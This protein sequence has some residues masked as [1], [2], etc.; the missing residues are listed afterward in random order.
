MGGGSGMDRLLND[1]R[2]FPSSVREF[3]VISAGI[4]PTGFHRDLL[5]RFMLEGHCACHIQSRYQSGQSNLTTNRYL[6]TRI[7]Y[8]HNYQS[9]SRE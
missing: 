4:N 7:P 2:N 3:V 5:L 6:C 8:H 9:V 1:R